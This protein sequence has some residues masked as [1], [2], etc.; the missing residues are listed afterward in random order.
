MIES[1]DVSGEEREYNI[2]IKSQATGASL[3]LKDLKIQDGFGEKIIMRR[4]ISCHTDYFV[5]ICETI[6]VEYTGDDN[7]RK[8]SHFS[9]LESYEIQEMISSLCENKKKVCHL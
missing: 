9:S 1:C 5:P 7:K 4:C 6:F 2:S 3:F 8:S